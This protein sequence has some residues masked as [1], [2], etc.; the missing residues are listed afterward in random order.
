MKTVIITGASS[1][2]GLAVALELA[3]KQANLL[4]IGHDPKRSELALEQIR[5]AAPGVNARFINADLM[6]QREVLRVAA[7]LS[8]I[9]ANEFGG[10]LDA[11]ISNAGCV[12]SWYTTTEE[13]YEQQFALNHLAGF[14][15]T[16]QLLPFLK[17]AN[18]RVILTGSESHKH[19]K[20]R[21]NDVM[22]SSG[23]NPLIAYKQSKLCNMLF[24]RGLNNRYHTEGIHAYVVD[25]GLV[26]TD[27]GNKNTGAL[28][29]WIWKLRKKHGVRPDIPAK[30]YVHLIET[31]PAP[32][33]LYFYLC[34]PNRYSREVTKENADR[35][36]ALSER[37][38]GLRYPERISK[39][40][41]G[42]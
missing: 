37:L 22:L 21:W 41:S 39:E 11:L 17:R 38:C 27:I 5:A 18:G 23:Y 31:E 32:Q 4:C 10:K 13:G 2:I 9:L 30:T 8:M 34:K 29:N 14:L 16:Q 24:A 42:I 26:C 20:M 19:M 1:G 15:L 28:V 6:Q 12:R 33:D 35:L 25:P 40:G 36:F 7:E 3:P